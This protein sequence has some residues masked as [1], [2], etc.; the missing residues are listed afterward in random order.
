[1]KKIF[2]ITLFFLIGISLIF[3]FSAEAQ[4]NIVPSWI[5]NTTSFWVD[6][7]VS[8]TE[9]INAVKFLIESEILVIETESLIDD[10]GDFYITYKENP[11]TPFENSSRDW[12]ISNE[13]LELQTEFLNEL[14]RLP[15]DVEILAMECDEANMFYDWELKQIILCYEFIDQVYVDFTAYYEDNPDLHVTDDDIT[16]MIYDVMDFIFYHEVGHALADVYELPITGLE[17]NAVDQF[18]TMSMFFYEYEPDA[19][20]ITGQDILYN[21]GTWFFIQTQNNYERI[22]WD[23][24]NLDIQRF[25][26]ISCYSYGQN[27]DYNQDLI[28]EGWLPEDRAI[29]CEYEYIT[30]IDSWNKLLEPYYQ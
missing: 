16:V 12:L 6:G 18:A 1:L 25:Y 9:F 22:Y 11:N 8:D 15:Y 28:D 2:A 30:L 23:T 4:E 19:D 14:F 21:V 26:N 29:N 3:S 7:E 24:H 10:Q 20:V 17:E 13:Y 5:K 27:P